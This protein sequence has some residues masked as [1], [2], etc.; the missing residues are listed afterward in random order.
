[1][2]FKGNQEIIMYVSDSSSWAHCL[3]YVH[4]LV[5]AEADCEAKPEL[6]QEAWLELPV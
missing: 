1:M 6:T 5:K 3:A 2:V 4:V